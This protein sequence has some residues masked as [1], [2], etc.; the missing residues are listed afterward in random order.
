[1]VNVGMAEARPR[2]LAASIASLKRERASM[3]EGFDI[4]DLDRAR[5]ASIAM[6]M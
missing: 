6:V 3:V 4:V 2:R 5:P 1:M